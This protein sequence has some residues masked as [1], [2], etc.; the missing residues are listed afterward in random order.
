MPLLLVSKYNYVLYK[1][2][3]MRI[4]LYFIN[5]NDSFYLPFIKKWYGEFCEKIIMYDNYSSDQSLKIA[6][7]LGFE[8]RFFGRRGMLNDQHYLD[9]KNHCWK[10][11]RDK[12][13]DY[14]IVCDADE[15]VTKPK[16]F[17]IIPKVTGYNMISDNLPV[18]NIQEINIGEY[19]LSYSKQAIFS[20]DSVEEINY[21]HGCHKNHL[22]IKDSEN[23]V[24]NFANRVECQLYHFRQ[25]G[26]VQRMIERHREYRRR[27]S[28][29]NKT[30]KMGYH[31]MSSDEEK[32]KEFELLKASAEKLW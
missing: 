16:R 28:E 21:V 11:Q 24:F 27:M 12:G 23:N 2:I 32:I 18:E 6:N 13:I 8:V 22:K 14:V 4:V 30:H 25:I 9:V 19:S 15:F 7:D 31:Y 3:V 10:E 5:F 17:S 20:P 29:F 1:K 26:G